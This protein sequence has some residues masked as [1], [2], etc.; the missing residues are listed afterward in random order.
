MFA[1]I[2]L[3]AGE[4]IQDHPGII[5]ILVTLG[6]DVLFCLKCHVGKQINTIWGFLDGNVKH[7]MIGLYVFMYYIV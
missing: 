4:A 1:H 3:C 7:Y 2:Y 5:D 6:N